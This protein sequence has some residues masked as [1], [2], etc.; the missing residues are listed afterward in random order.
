MTVT[1]PVCGMQVDI[2]KAAAHEDHGGWAYFFCSA[3]CHRLFRANPE[4]YVRREGQFAASS[5][6]QKD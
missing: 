3:Q 4:R 2:G 6:S 1:D 5:P